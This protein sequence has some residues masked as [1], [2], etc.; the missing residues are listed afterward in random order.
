VRSLGFGQLF[1]A[2]RLLG[3]LNEFLEDCANGPSPLKQ[4]FSDDRTVASEFET[5]DFA[6]ETQTVQADFVHPSNYIIIHETN[7]FSASYVCQV[8]YR[9]AGS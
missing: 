6:E 9:L 8:T 1:H 7:S 5:D 2:P 4:R 3:A